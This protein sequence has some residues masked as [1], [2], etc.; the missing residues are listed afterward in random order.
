[1]VD[2]RVPRFRRTRRTVH[3]RRRLRDFTPRWV[4]LDQQLASGGLEHRALVR[5]RAVLVARDVDGSGTFHDA[6]VV[7]HHTGADAR[8]LGRAPERGTNRSF[9]WFSD[10][11]GNGWMLHEITAPLPGR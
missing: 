2:A 7:Y 10:P 5:E 8:L 4:R 3:I 9:E 6:G 11:D 1:M